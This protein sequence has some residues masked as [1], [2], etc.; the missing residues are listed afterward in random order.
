MVKYHLRRKEKEITDDKELIEI[1]K[2]GKYAT[3]S[4]CKQNEAYLVTLSY[5]YDEN[6][7]A[8]YFHCAKEGQKIDYIKSNPIVCGTVIEDNGYEDG[9]GQTFRSVVFRG[10]ISIVEKLREK[11]FGFDVM[12]NQLEKDP[13]QI[14][15]KFF[16]DE[17]SYKNPGMIRLDVMSITGKE[18]KAES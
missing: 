11:I 8:L 6:K 12:L 7:N 18:E 15:N 13:I 3:I 4:M 1:L 9:C 16:K 17:E 2:G 5:G 14:K 10:K